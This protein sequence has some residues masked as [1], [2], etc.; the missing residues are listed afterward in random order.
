MATTTRPNVR[1]LATESDGRQTCHP[2]L[3]T[4]GA[5]QRELD[6]MRAV[7]SIVR[8]EVR[9]GTL[10]GP[11]VIGWTRSNGAVV[12]LPPCQNCSRPARLG[13]VL[14]ELCAQ[15]TAEPMNRCPR[16]AAPITDP[17][18]AARHEAVCA[19]M[20]ARD[21]Q[22][23]AVVAELRA[24]DYARGPRSPFVTRAER[25][26]L[27]RATC[28]HRP[29]NLPCKACG[30]GMTRAEQIARQMTRQRGTESETA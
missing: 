27:T 4:L 25:H 28:D 7:P 19:R 15:E 10:D 29:D 16:C 9:Q 14:C 2:E 8:I 5:A 18:H 3:L 12:E 22:E 30:L 20:A 17:G 21:A 1:V 11:V 24:Q 13:Q 26:V 23:T 6:V